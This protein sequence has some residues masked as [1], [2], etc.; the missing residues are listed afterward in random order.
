MPAGYAVF[1]FGPC[2]C[3]ALQAVLCQQPQVRS[4]ISMQQQNAESGSHDSSAGKGKGGQGGGGCQQ[5][6]HI[7]W[8]CATL[9]EG[10][11]YADAILR[12]STPTLMSLG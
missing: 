11:G 1:I 10:A 3:T 9:G 7:G 6:K 2:E 5:I 12:V 8:S 4:C